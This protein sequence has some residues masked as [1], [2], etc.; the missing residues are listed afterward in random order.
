MNYATFRGRAS[1]SEFWYFTLFHSLIVYAPV[2]V[3]SVLDGSFNSY[4]YS[5]DSYS[6]ASEAREATESIIV[7]VGV[8]VFVGML[9]TFIPMLATTWRRLHDSNL[10]GPLFFLAFVPYGFI[11][12]IV[13]TILPSKPLGRRFDLR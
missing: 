10:A 8:F 3:L 1:R 6:A 9:G 7:G 2:I 4:I 5:S 12:V 13:L 11:A